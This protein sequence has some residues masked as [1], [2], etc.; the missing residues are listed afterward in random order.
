MLPHKIGIV[1]EAPELKGPELTIDRILFSKGQEDS[2]P[3]ASM[4]DLHPADTLSNGSDDG[5]GV[6]AEL[7]ETVVEIADDV[8]ELETVDDDLLVVVCANTDNERDKRETRVTIFT[9]YC[10]FVEKLLNSL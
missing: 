4:A 9:N 5:V 3:N 1:S 7:M 2:D 10:G 6:A 8:L